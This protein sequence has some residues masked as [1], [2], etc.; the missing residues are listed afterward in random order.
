M[1][2]VKYNLTE[3]PGFSDLLYLDDNEYSNILKLNRVTCRT[4]N[5]ARYSVITYDKNYLASDLA[6]TFGL[7][8]SVVVNSQNAVVSFAPPKSVSTDQFIQNYGIL[9]DG[10]VAEEFV[11]GTMINV[12]WDPSIGLTGG[13]EIATRN[14]PGATSQFFK[15]NNKTFREMFLDAAQQNNLSMNMLTPLYCYSFVLQHPE[16]RIVVPFQKPQ[17]Y[18]VGLYYI[19]NL[20]LELENKSGSNSNSNSVSVTVCDHQDD[21]IKLFFET[22]GVTVKFPEVYKCDTYT[23]LI[24]K[25][26]SMNTPYCV[27]GVVLHNKNTGERAKI[28]NPVYEQVRSLRGNQPKLQYQ[29][30]CLRKEGKIKDYLKYYPEH[31]KEFSKF[32][33]QVHL[34]T[35]TLYGNYRSCY[36][37][38]LKPICD[39]SI[40]YRS[41]MYNIHFL[42]LHTMREQKEF[43]T[44]TTVQKYVNELNPSLLM[45]ALNYQ[46]RKRNIDSL[47][48]N[49][50]CQ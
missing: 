45:Y 6:R 30:L 3:I 9:E 50:T 27:V 39:Y 11:E 34:F 13:W 18:L 41:H 44:S 17:L 19:E 26:A 8:R 5:N 15:G 43:I 20:K 49:L 7:C 42:Y 21:K 32:R 10:V 33:D 29:Y 24:E 36:I 28:R 47:Y 46:M 37:K 1:E 23:E 22:L 4:S 2:P 31:K 35:E 14:I 38:K 40:E 16:N 48:V 12:F 25:Y